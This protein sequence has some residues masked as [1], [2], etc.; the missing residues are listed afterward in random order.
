MEWVDGTNKVQHCDHQIN[1]S[2]QKNKTGVKMEN[3]ID[4][5]GIGFFIIKTIKCLFIILIGMVLLASLLLYNM[6]IN[7]VWPDSV[8][9]EAPGNQVTNSKQIGENNNA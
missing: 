3:K 5:L 4:I 6:D 7:E 2:R 8:R 9:V 1:I